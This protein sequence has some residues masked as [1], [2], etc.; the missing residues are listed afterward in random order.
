MD[1][2]EIFEG[3]QTTHH[4]DQAGLSYL[5]HWNHSNCGD[6]CNI[7]KKY[8]HCSFYFTC[9]SLYF[10]TQNRTFRWSFVLNQ[11]VTVSRG[12]KSCKGNLQSGYSTLLGFSDQVLYSI[13]PTNESASLN[14]SHDEIS[15]SSP[16]VSCYLNQR[17]E[18]H[19]WMN[20]ATVF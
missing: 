7:L 17:V 18:Y 4:H 20:L 5:I 16:S 12:Y 19:T 11:N 15:W 14:L 6:C 9:T 10:E 1:K 8:S 3:T 13:L 2:S